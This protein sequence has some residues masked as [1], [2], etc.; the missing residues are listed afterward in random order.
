MQTEKAMSHHRERQVEVELEVGWFR[1][2]RNKSHTL[3]DN[4]DNSDAESRFTVIL[5]LK[6][7]G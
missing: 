2:I 1:T 6:R 4:S 7:Q 5:C 3:T